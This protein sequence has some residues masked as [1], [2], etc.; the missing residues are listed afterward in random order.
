MVRVNKVRIKRFFAYTVLF[1]FVF[2]LFSVSANWNPAHA[3]LGFSV[4]T[5]QLI[6]SRVVSAGASPAKSVVVEN[7]FLTPLDFT[8]NKTGSGEFTVTNGTSFSLDPGEQRS[9][10]VTF[11]PSS[12]GVKTGN[13]EIV[14]GLE[15]ENVALRGLG[16]D[17][18]GSTNE[19]SLQRILDT[20][21]YNINVGDNNPESVKINDTNGGTS[22]MLGQEVPLQRL[23]KA[24]GGNVTIQVLAAYAQNS[25]PVVRVGY[26]PLG[27]TSSKTEIFSVNNGQHQMLQ[28]GT[29]GS[30]SFNPGNDGFGL[31]STWPIL[32][33]RNVYSE[34]S[35]NTFHAAFPHKMR[36]YPLGGNQ[37]IA[38]TEEY[39][40][41]ADA[42]SFDY[43]DVVYIISN[44]KPYTTGGAAQIRVQNL[45]WATLLSLGIPNTGWMN[46]WM[47]F[48]R[49]NG[50]IGEHKVA[51]RQVMRVFNDGGSN[52]T[53]SSISMSNG[54]WFRV[55]GQSSG[56]IIPS[57][58]YHDFEVQF[59][60]SGGNKGQRKATMTINSNGGNVTVD[61]S[62]GYQSQPEG[63]FEYFTPETAKVFGFATN[64]GNIPGGRWEAAG[65][66]VLSKRWK[67][68]NGGQPVYVRQLAALH[69]CCYYGER[70]RLNWQSGGGTDEMYHHEDWSQTLLPIKPDGG[71]AE[72]LLSSKGN[73][74]FTPLVAGSMQS[75]ED[76]CENIHAIRWWPARDKNGGLIPNTYLVAQ[77]YV[78]ADVTNYD[79]NDN[80]Y[81]VTNVM[82]VDPLPTDI[83][84]TSSVPRAVKINRPLTMNVTVRNND[85]TS[86]TEDA[87]LNVTLPE[88]FIYNGNNGGCTT[89]GTPIVMVCNLGDFTPQ[90][91]K[92]I[93]ISLMPTIIGNTTTSAVVTALTKDWKPANNL[94]DIKVKIQEQAA[95]VAVNDNY[96]V[97]QATTLVV[98]IV[99][100]ILANDT[101]ANNEPLTA[102]LQTGV[103]PDKGTLTLNANGSFTFVPA[104]GFAGNATFTYKAHDDE[105]PSDSAAT[106][107]IKVK[108]KSPTTLEDG[109]TLN[110]DSDFSVN[111]AGGVLTNDTAYGG[112]SL[113][114]VLVDGP[115]H[116]KTFSLKPNGAF[117]YTPAK[118]FSG[119]DSFT[120]RA[121]DGDND[122]D[123]TI[124]H[125]TVTAQPD[126]PVAE[127]DSY[128]V[129]EN[130]VLVI[131]A[132]NGVL[133]NDTD[134]DGNPLSASL[135]P[136]SGTN[137][138]VLTFN[139]NG[140]LT[141][142]P[143]ADY[144]GEDSFEYTVSD[145]NGGSDTASVTITVGA[146]NKA[147]VVTVDSYI[148]HRNTPLVVNASDGPL[149]NDIDPNGDIMTAELTA[150]PD[151]LELSLST[152]GSFTYT[153]AL[154]FLGV[155][156]FTYRV[157]DGRGG[158]A[159]SV[160]QIMVIDEQ[161]PIQLIENGSF[162]A[163]IKPAK[164]LPTRWTAVRVGNDTI[165][166]NT[167]KKILASEGA[168][169]YNFKGDKVSN[170]SLYQNPD[171]ANIGAGMTLQL[172]ASVQGTKVVNKAAK[173]V[174]QVR[175][176]G[177]SKPSTSIIN[178]PK[179]TYGYTTVSTEVD[180][181]APVAQIRV[182]A[183]YGPTGKKGNFLLDDVRLLLTEGGEGA[184]A[185]GALAHFN[186]SDATS[187]VPLP[188]APTDLRDGN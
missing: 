77:D 87:V 65:E 63:N 166:C 142:T 15:A 184:L 92:T 80:I 78:A 156:Q 114:A 141:Y 127:N 148:A 84:V 17:G 104:A 35:L 1:G 109:Y 145:G 175:Y 188:A 14:A 139:T 165:R 74:V 86:I 136:D 44:V 121:N 96:D 55:N 12:K 79:Y 76:V 181:T 95:P 161:P 42:F 150:N 73:G 110:E 32:S 89:S 66:E 22:S 49:I 43:N 129:E 147:P 171:P 117:D 183:S 20:F 91:S 173:L 54:S 64:I 60:A 71:P 152:N 124:V 40:T 164:K 144:V 93:G 24:G 122:S 46:T 10:T 47:T 160:A 103:T 83:S 11:D 169:A 125:L 36:F 62:G 105:A 90:Q 45:Q 25:T 56:I 30:L 108:R 172:T 130:D 101:D 154:N 58:G 70:I 126:A 99:N 159:A 69:Q 81:I 4:S 106:V 61:L 3:A 8:V 155:V 146:L 100:G 16:A 167:T 186:Q 153:P 180:I 133:S 113:T 26:Y 163:Q 118:N 97:E 57:G 151:E 23:Q 182:T 33:N 120:Y 2:S 50:G 187:T 123:V 37:Y 75:C 5:G 178:L 39:H 38:T 158:S 31:Y 135:V 112:A 72:M 27:N 162:E 19:P 138:G 116:A 21:G 51:D 111:A 52:L 6:F 119:A 29:S 140:S 85:L 157:S 128:D 9:I 88:N 7:T 82:P 174:L 143:A 168:C 59:I 41:S 53:V 34:D 177:K 176:V 48:A 68:A 179:G 170:S 185:D 132:I 13:L 67:V 98:K 107:T 131:G 18:E 134:A 94:L 115:S 149:G 102:V 137:H 28:P